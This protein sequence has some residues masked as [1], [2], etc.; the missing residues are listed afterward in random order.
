MAD[1]TAE[2]QLVTDGEHLLKK[3][4]AD[5]L[6]IDKYGQVQEQYYT[7]AQVRMFIN[8]SL[9]SEFS[10]IRFVAKTDDGP[11]YSYNAKFFNTLIEGKFS[12]MGSFSVNFTK[13]GY[14]MDL[15]NAHTLETQPYIKEAQRIDPTT[16]RKDPLPGG[17]PK[18]V[19]Q[20]TKAE[21]S[22]AIWGPQSTST[23]EQQTQLDALKKK[24]FTITLTYGDPNDPFNRTT[25]HRISVAKIVSVEQQ[26]VVNDG[27]NVQEIYNFIARS[28]DDP[29]DI[30]NNQVDNLFIPK[31]PDPTG[32]EKKTAF[33]ELMNKIG[34][35]LYTYL[36]DPDNISFEMTPLADNGY[37]KDTPVLFIDHSD[38]YQFT[39]I[40]DLEKAAQVDPTISY[41]YQKGSF[42]TGYTPYKAIYKKMFTGI[43]DLA[44]NDIKKF[45]QVNY[46]NTNGFLF[47]IKQKLT[48]GATFPTTDN[49]QTMNALLDPANLFASKSDTTTYANH[50]KDI[51]DKIIFSNDTNWRMDDFVQQDVQTLANS[52][53]I[54]GGFDY[55]PIST[56]FSLDVPTAP[57]VFN[58]D[59]QLTRVIKSKMFKNP[60][61]PYNT[62]VGNLTV[63]DGTLTV[64]TEN[65]D[66]TLDRIN[67]T[68][69][70][71]VVPVGGVAYLEPPATLIA[72]D[73]F[74]SILPES[75]LAFNTLD[76]KV[77]DPTIRDVIRTKRTMMTALALNAS[78]MIAIDLNSRKTQMRPDFQLFMKRFIPDTPPDKVRVLHE[79]SLNG[80]SGNEYA[81]LLFLESVMGAGD[82]GP[83]VKSDIPFPAI[84]TIPGLKILDAE[85]DRTGISMFISTDADTALE[86]Y[87]EGS[88]LYVSVI[89]KPSNIYVKDKYTNPYTEDLSPINVSIFQAAV[90]AGKVTCFPFMVTSDVANKGQ[91]ADPS[92]VMMMVQKGTTMQPITAASIKSVKLL[93]DA[94][95]GLT[96]DKYI[97]AIEMDGE[98]F[99]I[100]TPGKVVDDA[101][102]QQNV[103][104]YL[105]ALPPWAFILGSSRGAGTSRLR[106]ITDLL[107][108]QKA[109]DMNQSVYMFINNESRQVSGIIEGV[110]IKSIVP[111]I[112]T[113]VTGAGFLIDYGGFIRRLAGQLLQILGTGVNAVNTTKQEI[114]DAIYSGYT[115]FKASVSISSNRS[116][117][118]NTFTDENGMVATYRFFSPPLTKELEKLLDSSLDPIPE[119]TKQNQSF[120]QM[121]KENGFHILKANTPFEPTVVGRIIIKYPTDI[122]KDGTTHSELELH[123]LQMIP[124]I[125]QTELTTDTAGDKILSWKD[126]GNAKRGYG[127]LCLFHEINRSLASFK[128]L[129]KFM[130]ATATTEKS[131]AD[132]IMTRLYGTDTPAA[133]DPRVSEALRRNLKE[134]YIGMTLKVTR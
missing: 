38:K 9:V 113:Y 50:L 116:N 86:T 29:N 84:D 99:N 59:P 118:P 2:Q 46:Q 16:K 125:T 121:T 117:I 3:V 92:C 42:D 62:V 22:N 24:L 39:D 111:K 56:S 89:N 20:M 91:I 134:S 72:E 87:T 74:A 21:L 132:S 34:E 41:A 51:A 49:S 106:Y 64:L 33:L 120:K 32:S 25:I 114:E 30:V 27:S 98:Q 43:G 66:Y 55:T 35:R 101:G 68:I 76:I 23:A 44:D 6:D 36:S 63:K 53:Q 109:E 11:A 48:K 45:A 81:N 122:V 57:A 102:A 54:I 97:F 78:K 19:Q 37:L 5:A 85:T 52:I 133:T 93:T 1:A 31:L 71:S 75:N 82:K 110:N 105:R 88:T 100:P 18:S 128:E 10:S 95:G 13:S 103:K 79:T 96:G 70:F 15:L 4:N 47:K 40:T 126:S 14:V 7:S 17:I 80:A 123:G 124:D 131:M 119:S 129:N 61:S 28:I 83:K 67:G 90:A 69:R 104:V 73:A 77:T 108:Q 65:T 130:T 12:V 127:Q 26:V 8:S 58:L 112:G 94:V 115:Q 60:L 107:D